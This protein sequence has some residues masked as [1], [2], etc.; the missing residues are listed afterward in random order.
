MIHSW[1]RVVTPLFYEDPLLFFKFCP[2]PPPPPSGTV[3]SNLVVDLKIPDRSGVKCSNTNNTNI[4]ET[5]LIFQ[6][7][8]KWQK[9]KA[10]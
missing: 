1:Q 8:R 7:I 6:A 10:K 5:D 2:N 4:T 9:L 3:D